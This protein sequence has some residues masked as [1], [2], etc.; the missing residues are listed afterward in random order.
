MR[1]PNVG[2]AYVWRSRVL[3]R[4]Q[5]DPEA[6]A[7]LGITVSDVAAACVSSATNPSGRIGREPAPPGRISLF[8]STQGRLQTPEQFND[9]VVRAA[10]WV[11]RAFARRRRATLEPQLRLRRAAQRPAHRVHAALSAAG[12]ERAGGQE[13]HSHAHG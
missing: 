5:L 4:L 9:I 8:R 1:L 7:K 3:D 2:N 6:M 10:R 11:A 13:G 12:R